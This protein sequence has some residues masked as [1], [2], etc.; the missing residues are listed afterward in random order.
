MIEKIG[1]RDD[2]II[3]KMALCNVEEGVLAIGYVDGGIELLNI[4]EQTRQRF[5]CFVN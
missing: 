3:S 5:E 2:T 1:I 4:G